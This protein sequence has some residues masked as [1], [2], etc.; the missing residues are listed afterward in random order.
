[1]F[2]LVSTLLSRTNTAVAAFAVALLP[3]IALSQVQSSTTFDKDATL[4]IGGYQLPQSELVSDEFKKAY[5]Q[6]LIDAKSWP[7]LAPP[8]N[9]PRAEWDRFDAETD[10]LIFGPS[11]KWAEEH[12][13][14]NVVETKLA[15]VP[16]GIITPKNGIDP[17]NEHRVLINLHG[18]G[19][20]MGRGLVAGKGESIPVAAAGQAGFL[21]RSRSSGCSLK[22]SLDQAP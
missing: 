18:G 22:G 15:G 5:T 17:R 4:H 6:H 19:F 12:Y 10:H 1:M 13:P 20:T 11:V 14:V 7:M 2:A 3:G 21:L 8:V 9:A 16:V